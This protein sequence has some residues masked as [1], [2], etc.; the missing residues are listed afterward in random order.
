[1]LLG[2]TINAPRFLRHFR[3]FW[4]LP[5]PTLVP[6]CQEMIVCLLC[7]GR[8]GAD[9]ESSRL[10]KVEGKYMFTADV[11][12]FT[13]IHLHLH[14]SNWRMAT[15]ELPNGKQMQRLAS[16]QQALALANMLCVH[17]QLAVSKRQRQLTCCVYM[18]THCQLY[19]LAVS[20]RWRQLTCYVYMHTHCSCTSQP[21]ASANGQLALAS[22]GRQHQLHSLGMH[23]LAQ[24][25]VCV[26]VFHSGANHFAF[27]SSSL[28][29]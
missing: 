19:Q 13:S 11:Q 3:A 26:H 2:G 5:R 16:R 10:W 18:H 25:V 24:L 14:I 27:T 9:R 1:M 23:Q 21:L 6:P 12:C 17:D 8:S 22:A 7:V 20:K 15:N 28:G 29:K 4:D